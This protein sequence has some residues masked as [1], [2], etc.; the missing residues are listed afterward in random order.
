M[1]RQKAA[2]ALFFALGLALPAGIAA[3]GPA[4]VPAGAAKDKAGWRSLFD[5]KSL[6]SWKPAADGDKE[7]VS[8][9]DGAIVLAAGKPMTAVSYRGG[10]FPKTDYEV[11]L[12]GKK[13]DGED[14]FCTTTFP[15]GDSFCS[16]VVGGWG[17]TTVGLS[18]VNYLDASE[19]E[20]SSRRDFKKDQWYR[21]RIRV[22]GD[23]IRAW[24]GDAK[25]VDLDTEDKK[26]S[27]RVECAPCKPFGVATYRTTGAI[28]DV[29]VRTLT[30]DEKKAAGKDKE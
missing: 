17:G 3:Q 26:I 10:D 1:T 28:R 30:P 12:E 14:F 20:T 18:S 25:V 19:N 8:V 29:R 13:L 6:G 7:R 15:V 16:L 4:K 2:A 5:G 11:T 27:I 9:K 24:I 23:K 22:T 21:V